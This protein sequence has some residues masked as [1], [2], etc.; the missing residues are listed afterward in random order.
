METVKP[1][2]RKIKAWLV[3]WE[4]AG[5]HA[6]LTDNVAA[7][8]N[9]RLSPERVR[10]FFELFYMNIQY[11][12]TERLTYTASKRKN[13]Y[14]ARS[15]RP[16]GYE[17]E[18]GH[19]PYLFARQVDDLVVERDEHGKEIA[20]WKDRRTGRVNHGGNPAALRSLL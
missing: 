15:I 5:N 16:W 17:I 13:P 2:R 18:C 12:L 7:I 4:G 14:P 3:T 1:R 20:S 6:K 10:D 11:S 8:L 9:P 19:N